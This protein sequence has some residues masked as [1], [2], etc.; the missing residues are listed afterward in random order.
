[1]AVVCFGLGLLAGFITLSRVEA[2]DTRATQQPYATPG[3]GTPATPYG[4]YVILPRWQIIAVPAP[5][6]QAPLVLLLDSETGT[7]FV[8]RSDPNAP[9]QYR[10]VRLSL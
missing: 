8:L 7:S 9:G 6:Q 10:W 3:L 4:S 2:Q 1:M 5:Q